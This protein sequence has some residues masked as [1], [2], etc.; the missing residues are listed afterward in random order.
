MAI[1][2]Y[3]HIFLFFT[4][5]ISVYIFYR[6][7]IQRSLSPT[8]WPLLGMIPSTLC[9]YHRFH[10]YTTDILKE[11]GGTFMYKGPW[12]AG[13]DI[14]ITSDPD[15]FNYISTTNFQNYPK[16]PKFREIFDILGDGIFNSDSELWELHRKTTMSLFKEDS[17]LKLVEKTTWNNI[18]KKLMPVLDYMS[19]RRSKIDLQNIFQRLTFDGIVSLITDFDPETLTVDLPHDKFEE[20]FTKSEET[21]FDR[22]F[23]PKC[24]WKILN[25]FQIGNEKHLVNA[26]KLSDELIYKFI[27]EKRIKETKTDDVKKEQVED[28]SLLTRYM[29]EYKDQTGSF[30]DHDKFIKDTLLS[31]LVAGRGST[32]AALTWFFYL[33]LRNPVAE[34]RIYEELHEK[35][36][37]KEDEKWKQFGAKELENL[38]YLHGSLCEALRLFPPVPLNAKGPQEIDTLPSGH[39][40]N[41]GTK[42]LLHSYAMGRMETIWGQDCLEFKPERWISQKGGIKHIP[43]YKFT[44]FHAGPRTC[45]GKKI[46]LLQMKIVAATIIYNYKVYAIEGLPGTLKASTNL[47]LKYG[48]MVKVKKRN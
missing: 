9:N 22:H 15:N 35:L 14:L 34:S 38:V 42:I 11:N 43:S 37:M 27:L 3:P 44:A 32:A 16:G 25:R 40:V 13:I 39:R 31:L 7:K 46:S 45:L 41:S 24:W 17:F 48:L 28:L 8:N 30:G 19:K 23:L 36:G 26:W 29:R 4:C 10:E 12:F 18:E 21:I 1:T 33:L 20:A 47:Q 5:F 2:N 6:L